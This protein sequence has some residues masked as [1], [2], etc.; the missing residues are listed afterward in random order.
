MKLIDLDTAEQCA[1]A[2][3]KLMVALKSG[4]GDPNPDLSYTMYLPESF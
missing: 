2:I 4:I 3:H 1:A